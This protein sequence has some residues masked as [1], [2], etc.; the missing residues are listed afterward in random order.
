MSTILEFPQYPRRGNVRD[1]FSWHIPLRVVG[2]ALVLG[3]VLAK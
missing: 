2:Y 1:R 3:L